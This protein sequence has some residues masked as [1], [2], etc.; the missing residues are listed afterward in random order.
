[1]GTPNGHVS[2]VKMTKL[3]FFDKE[4]DRRSFSCSHEVDYRQVETS[5][6][7]NIRQGKHTM[8]DNNSGTHLQKIT[9]CLWFNDK[10]EEAATFYTSLFKNSKIDSISYYGEAGP[11]PAGMVMM[12]SFQLDGQAFLAL[13]GGPEFTF[14]PAISFSVSCETQQEINEL[15]EQLSSDGG[16]EI[17]CGWVT[18][19]FGLSWQIVPTIMGELMQDKDPER[20]RRVTEAMFKMKK[21]DIKTLQEA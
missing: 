21:L 12:V 10:A 14:S 6:I 9:S 5:N 15:W 2:Y 16:K 7:S 13:N 8:A 1:M 11:R 20:V 17:D 18:D 3:Y 19:K 4:Q